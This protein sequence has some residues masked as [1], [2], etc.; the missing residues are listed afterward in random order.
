MHPTYIE[1]NK[2]KMAQRERYVR[3]CDNP[4]RELNIHHMK[5][6]AINE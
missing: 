6:Q 3:V 5:M 2:L 1:T 4:D